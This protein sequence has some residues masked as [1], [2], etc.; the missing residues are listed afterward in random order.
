MKQGHSGAATS[1]HNVQLICIKPVICAAEVYK[2]LSYVM[3]T[4]L[5]DQKC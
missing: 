4:E 5:Y 2:K 1:L 3:C